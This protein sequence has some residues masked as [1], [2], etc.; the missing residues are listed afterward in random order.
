MPPRYTATEKSL[1][2]L[3]TKESHAVTQTGH[4]YSQ[5]TH[6]NFVNDIAI[7]HKHYYIGI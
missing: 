1:V 6:A 7:C 2:N 5:T 3:Q 4:N